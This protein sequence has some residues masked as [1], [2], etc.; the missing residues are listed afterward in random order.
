MELQ[1]LDHIKNAREKY[2]PEKTSCLFIAE[3]PPSDPDRFFYFE[4]VREQN[5]LYL[6]NH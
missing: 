6:E 2:K 5:S 4:E 1:Q 3:A